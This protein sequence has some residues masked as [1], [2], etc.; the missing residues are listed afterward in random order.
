[1]KK[2]ND[3]MKKNQLVQIIMILAMAVAPWVV[4]AQVKQ[5]FKVV[6]FDTKQPI[7]AATNILFGQTITTD[8]KGV[9]VVTLP[10]DKKD[11]YLTME[12]WNKE[13][14]MELGRMPESF[15]KQFQTKDTIKYYMADKQA[16]RKEAKVMFDS[17]YR[18][19]YDTVI[20][21]TMQVYLDSIAKAP[22]QKNM[23]A[24]EI[25]STFWSLDPMAKPCISD[26]YDISRYGCYEYADSKYV[27]VLLVL[28]SGDVN[29]AVEMAKERV[30]LADNSR[31]NLEWA[32]FYRWTRS[33]DLATMDDSPM[34]DYTG[35][36]Y[37]NRFAQDS[38]SDYI[39]DLNRD[40]LY[41][42]A[43]SVIRVEKP[44]NRMPRVNTVLVPSYFRYV[45]GESD[46]A[47]LKAGQILKYN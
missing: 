16:Y 18:F 40:N 20:R 36:L 24:N 41:E 13:G 25:L 45:I 17:L 43:D 33:L 9:A 39:Q 6:D 26:A 32:E 44:G 3:N 11:A 8:S 46:N 34:S 29:K 7:A 30:N 27:D 21:H 47:K 22:E 37:R 2:Y 23:L 28:R 19:V 31:D 4:G 10:A 12:D 1:M 38:Y 5:V 15:F 35:L 42:K 14:Y